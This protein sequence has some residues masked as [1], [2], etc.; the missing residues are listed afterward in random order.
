MFLSVIIQCLDTKTPTY[1][2]KVKCKFVFLIK[3]YSNDAQNFNL[4][5]NMPG[6]M[7]SNYKNFKSMFYKTRVDEN[8]PVVLPASMI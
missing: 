4:L 8:N 7:Y 6:I 2:I 3:Q 1:N 5:Y